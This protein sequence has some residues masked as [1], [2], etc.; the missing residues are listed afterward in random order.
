[1]RFLWIRLIQIAAAGLTAHALAADPANQLSAAEKANGWKLLFDGQTPQGWHSFKKST[2]PAKGWLVEDGW[3][4]CLGQNGGDIL[5]DGEYDQFDLEWD[6]KLETAGNSGL[7]YFV[8]ESRNSAIGHEYQM[9]DDDLNP[10]GKVAQGKHVT[11]SFYDVLKPEIAPPSKPMGQ[12]NHSRILVKGN[13]VEHW[14]NGVKVLEYECGSEA[15]KEGV[16]ASK[17]KSVSG[18]GTPLKGH[19]LLQDHHS[20]VWFRNLKLRDLSESK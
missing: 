10:D 12:V 16:A 3:L 19:L 2:F 20:K 11:A 7:K 14:L 17:F 13:H 6:W 5:S 1:M 15:V 18:F 8:L 9:L 4:Y